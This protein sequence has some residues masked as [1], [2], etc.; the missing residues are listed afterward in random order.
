LNENQQKREEE[1]QVSKIF[2]RFGPGLITG[3]A[4][5]DL[6]ELPLTLKQGR[7]SD[8]GNFGLQCGCCLL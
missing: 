2:V 6:R 3:A 7:S 4:D 5:D 1:E 8:L